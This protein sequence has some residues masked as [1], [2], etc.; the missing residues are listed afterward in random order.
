TQ[1]ATLRVRTVTLKPRVLNQAAKWLFQEIQ[2][3]GWHPL[4]RVNGGGHFRPDGLRRFVP[5]KRMVP[6]VGMSWHGQGTAFATPGRQL[7]GTLLAWW[8][9]GHK[10]P[11]L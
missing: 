3:L 10:Q 8:G 5:L 1:A 11:W 2:L 6:R 4:M 7:A 9:L